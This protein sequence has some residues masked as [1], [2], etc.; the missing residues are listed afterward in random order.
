MTDI[1][2]KY[3]ELVIS[4]F[5]Y[6]AAAALAILVVASTYE[7]IIVQGQDKTF[8][9]SDGLQ[10][11][12]SRDLYGRDILLMLLNADS[13]IPEPKAIRINGSPVIK[14]DNNF[15]AQKIS[16]ISSIYS[17]TGDYKLSTMLDWKVESVEYI[18]SGTD[19]PY[20]R[21]NLKEVP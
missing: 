17:S 5:M 4:I 15:F 13:S 19:A 2:E 11:F 9:S 10:E 20:I 18:Y 12:D 6:I 21:Y 3:F 7:P 1:V 14:I 8:I 16:N